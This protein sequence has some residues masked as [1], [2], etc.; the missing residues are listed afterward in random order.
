[1]IRITLLLLCIFVLKINCF[2]QYCTQDNR[3]T[4]VEYFS[5]SQIDSN[6]DVVYGNA[7]NYLGNTQ[8]LKFD[9]YFPDSNSET[10]NQRPFILLIHGGSFIGGDKSI[11]QEDCKQFAKRG[12]VAAT[13]SYRLGFDA[14]DP[15]GQ[16]EAIYRAHQDANAAM[17]FIVNAADVYKIDTSW[18]FIGGGSAG[19]YTALNS[20][21]V[22]QT[23]WNGVYPTISTQL[24]GLNTSG[25]NLTNQYTFKGIYNNW[26][27][28]LMS[29]VQPSQMLPTISFHGLLDNTVPIGYSQ[30]GTVGG[31]AIINDAL[32]QNNVCSEL[33]VDS[34]GGDGIFNPGTV[35][36]KELR[37]GRAVC[38][39]KSVFCNN[40]SS[41]YITEP[42]QA[43]CSSPNSIEPILQ[44]KIKV[45]PNPFQDKLI[46]EGLPSSYNLV[47]YNTIGS[48]IHQT[49]NINNL[50]LNHLEKGVYLLQVKSD[51]Q[52]YTV[53]L[54]KE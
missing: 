31:S 25:N 46:I 12:F 35:Q 45:Y 43:N 42:L 24:G 22:N 41:Q 15:L 20:A 19:S 50:D 47:L 23:E 54:I 32:L 44:N 3:F 39:Y 30:N 1:M 29:A 8:D 40:C 21:Y 27:A 6:L 49:N 7:V 26:G 48:K 13:M 34:T 37:T 10:L 5:D 4:E 36:G 53:K 51:N 33:V 52:F 38:F 2:T 17:R 18:L 11:L 9:I 14:N 28:V 16:L